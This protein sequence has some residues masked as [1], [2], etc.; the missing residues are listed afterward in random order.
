[1]KLKLKIF[2]K[3]FLITAVVIILSLTFLN[4]I[5]S[6]FLSNFLANERRDILKES[7]HSIS[8][9]TA[10]RELS[11]ADFVKIMR[12]VNPMVTKTI[13]AEILITNPQGQPIYCSC[14]IFESDKSCIHSSSSVSQRMINKISTNS[15]LYEVGN[16]DGTLN[17]TYYIYG[18]K[19]LNANGVH[20]NLVFG[21]SP[22]SSIR[23]LYNSLLR[24]FITASFFTLIIMFF[25]VYYTSYSL[26]KPLRL[27]S[28]AAR[29]MAK[30]D[31][32]KRIPVTTDDEVGELAAAFNNMTDSLVLL[33]S[34]RRSFVANVSHELKT[35]ITTIGGFIDG[36]IDGTI[37]Y[38][39]KDE[40]LRIVSDEV[41][42][43]SRL[44]QSMLSLSKLESGEMKLK[45]SEFDI[46]ATIINIVIA[47][48]QRI[49]SKNLDIIGLDSLTKLYVNADSDLI[50][51]VIYNLV[52]N[53][54]KFTNDNGEI[55]FKVT[56][57]NNNI[58]ISIKNSGD[59]IT[60]E[61][62]PHIFERFY[63]VDRARSAV[64][65]STGLGLYIVKTII[66]IH[67]GKISVKSIPNKYTEFEFYIPNN[68]MKG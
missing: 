64:K 39:K 42:R 59:G 3:Y 40:Y 46:A 60:P 45:L 9:F 68:Q 1:M 30:G 63:K 28:E 47:Q 58:Y 32:S 16:F 51:Q 25:A 61:D 7:C 53:A 21:F 37:P 41:K 31:F 44:V 33:E 43:L 36:I 66:D 13:D 67:G 11:D 15:E 22:A 34:T 55:E 62:L 8:Q 29:C 49:E 24:M 27:M 4:A 52:D 26:T 23:T 38:E 50:H 56:N 20:N 48:Q 5:L 65:E 12:F 54:V 18:T 10:Q 19:L 35:P 17:D 2:K 57:R 14:E 6:F